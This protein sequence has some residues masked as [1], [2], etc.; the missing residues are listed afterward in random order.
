MRGMMGQRL[1]YVCMYVW[2]DCS[3][4]SVELSQV[5]RTVNCE[6]IISVI[7]ISIRCLVK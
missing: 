1:V 2:M 7:I 5:D 4:I 3:V 6:N